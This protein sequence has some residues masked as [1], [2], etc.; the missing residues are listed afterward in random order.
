MLKIDGQ[1][2]S[3]FVDKEAAMK[4][5]RD[6]KK[7]YPVVKAAVYDSKEGTNEFC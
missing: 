6:I 5:G 1:T 3:S 7:Q 4:A 2:K